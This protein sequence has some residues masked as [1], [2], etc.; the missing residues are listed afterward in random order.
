MSRHVPAA[1]QTYCVELWL[2]YPFNLKVKP[3]RVSK[4]GDYRYHKGQKS[5]LITVNASLNPYAFLITYLH[6]VAHLLAFQDHGFGI[7]PHG[8][9]WKKSFQHLMEPLLNR[10]VFPEDVLKPLSS[11]MR[12]PKAA[13]GSDQRLS[14][15]LQQYDRQDGSIALAEVKPEQQFRFRHM[16]L[17]KESVRRT[18]ALCRDMGSGRR[19]LI[20]EIARVHLIMEE[21]AGG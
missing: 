16:L 10:Q 19:Y 3:R 9:E 17:V 12:N 5:H 21:K 7:S 15:A 14:L 4:L 20:S 11:Y 13:S 18:R 1:A 2:K 6:E 8:R